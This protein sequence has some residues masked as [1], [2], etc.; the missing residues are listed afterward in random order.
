M[1]DYKEF[2]NRET[3]RQDWV[4][5][6]IFELLEQCAP[7]G[8]V[9]EWDIEDIS[10][11]RE[12][13]QEILVEKHKLMTELEFYPY[14]EYDAV[15]N[16][17]YKPDNTEMIITDEQIVVAIREAVESM[18]ADDLAKLAGDFIGGLCWYTNDGL[19]SFIPDENYCGGLDF[20]KENY[21][22]SE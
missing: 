21:N 22:V 11:I 8:A 5:G 4:D 20:T 14:R 1:A 19:Y 17:D 7:D 9:I 13:I 6:S 10:E 3:E 16:P 15:E 18:D 12:A 2:T